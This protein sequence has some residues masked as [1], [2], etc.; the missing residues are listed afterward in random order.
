MSAIIISGFAGIGKT[1]FTKN[2]LN[3][4][5]ILDLEPNTFSGRDTGVRNPNFLQN[6]IDFVLNNINNYDYIL[7]S[8]QKVVTDYL[9]LLNIKYFSVSPD[10]NL[11]SE[12]MKRLIDRNSNQWFID[13]MQEKWD[14]WTVYFDQNP[15]PNK[16]LLKSKQYLSDVIKE[17]VL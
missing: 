10:K 12:Y 11:K 4:F 13:L 7:I 5:K 2:Y 17:M 14:E 6:Y 8:S 15:N 1:T 3:K 9:N 16:I